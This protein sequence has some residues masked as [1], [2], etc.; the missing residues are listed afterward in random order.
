MILL[1]KDPHLYFITH[2]NLQP[3]DYSFF[4]RKNVLIEHGQS[5][6]LSPPLKK[7]LSRKHEDLNSISSTQQNQRNKHSTSTKQ[8]K[9]EHGGPTGSIVDPM[10]DVLSNKVE[11]ENRHSVLTSST[12]VQIQTHIQ[13]QILRTYT[14]TPTSAHICMNAYSTHVQHIQ[15]SRY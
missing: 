3:L 4:F 13:S 7:C 14:H 11:D 2:S 1:S 12:S 9:Y 15:N 6:H 5:P 10:R 8:T